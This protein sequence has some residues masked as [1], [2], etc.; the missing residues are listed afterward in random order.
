MQGSSS[1][2]DFRFVLISQRIIACIGEF[3]FGLHIFGQFKVIS[4]IHCLS[5]IDIY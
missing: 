1:K 2:F 3:E 5:N 4:F